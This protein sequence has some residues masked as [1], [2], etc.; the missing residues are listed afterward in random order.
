MPDGCFF[1]LVMSDKL[2]DKNNNKDAGNF[3]SWSA[4]ISFFHSTRLAQDMLA[5]SLSLN[6]HFWASK[7]STSMR[8][9]LPLWDPT[10]HEVRTFPVPSQFLL[11]FLSYFFYDS[12]SFL[13]SLVPACKNGQQ[14]EA[15]GAQSTDGSGGRNTSN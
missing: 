2:G 11:P 15:H 1:P 3:S 6:P 10:A 7:L 13:S 12:A 9:L 14:R 4:Y 8:D 5:G